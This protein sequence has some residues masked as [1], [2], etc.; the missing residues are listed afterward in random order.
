M[1]RVT[2]N[3]RLPMS[4]TLDYANPEARTQ[5]RFW[6]ALVVAVAGCPTATVAAAVFGYLAAS[7]SG[8]IPPGD[9]RGGR[10]SR[11][12]PRRA[13]WARRSGDLLGH[14]L[15]ERAIA[16]SIVASL[17][18]SGGVGVFMFLLVSFAAA[19]TAD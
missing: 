10:A 4:T 17:I 8:R 12:C 3:R 2:G 1:Y 13:R 18:V 16:I 7:G 15:A 14:W 19:N 11:P 6:P 9:F 5:P